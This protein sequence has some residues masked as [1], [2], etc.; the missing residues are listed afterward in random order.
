MEMMVVQAGRGQGWTRR[1]DVPTSVCH[2]LRAECWL[3][4]ALLNAILLK[5]WQSTLTC[6]ERIG[7]R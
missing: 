7:L 5:P 6:P 2:V 3:Q 4:R 1:A